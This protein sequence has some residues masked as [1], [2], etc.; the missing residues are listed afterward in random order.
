MGVWLITANFLVPESFVLVAV[1]VGLVTVFPIKLQQDKCYSLFIS[2][3]TT[4]CLNMNGK[5]FSFRGQNLIM[6]SPVYF[7][8]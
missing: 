5:V 7:N 6:G 3:K 2:E 8:L 1:H 4:F